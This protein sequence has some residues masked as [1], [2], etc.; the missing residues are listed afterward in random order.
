MSSFSMILVVFCKPKNM[1]Y[2]K[3]SELKQFYEIFKLFI[4]LL[5]PNE[6]GLE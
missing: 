6:F 4:T 1:P 5:A 2:E 3:S